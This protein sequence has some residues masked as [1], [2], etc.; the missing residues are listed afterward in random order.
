MGGVAAIGTECCSL[1]K[2]G[3]GSRNVACNYHDICITSASVHKTNKEILAATMGLS[4]PGMP[5]LTSAPQ[6][7]SLTTME[8]STMHLACF[9]PAVQVFWN[10]LRPVLASCCA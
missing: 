2:K 6:L 5:Q 3:G 10:Q 9:T 1:V 7:A 4:T 8:F